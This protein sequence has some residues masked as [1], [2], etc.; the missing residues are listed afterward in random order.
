MKFP[1][2][3]ERLTRET[4]EADVYCADYPAIS[5]PGGKW[6]L[7]IHD[8]VFEVGGVDT[9]RGGWR[10]SGI[11]HTEEEAC[12]YLYKYSTWLPPKPETRTPEEWARSKVINEALIRSLRGES[13]E[14]P[15]A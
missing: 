1:A 7:W 8:G 6:V 4:G 15:P 11:F 2:L 10:S 9:D 12:D 14:E 13:K 5:K 3:C